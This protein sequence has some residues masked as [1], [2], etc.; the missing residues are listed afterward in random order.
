MPCAFADNKQREQSFARGPMSQIDSDMS[1][2][3]SLTQH[4][5]NNYASA[6]LKQRPWQHVEQIVLHLPSESLDETAMG[7]AWSELADAHP[8]L[9][10]VIVTE[11]SGTLK[12]RATPPM[13]IELVVHDW[14][15]F[16]DAQA[17]DALQEFLNEDREAGVDA[18]AAPAFRVTLIKKGTEQ[19][20]L[21]WTFSCTLLD[22]RACA[23]LL[24]EVFQR[25]ASIRNGDASRNIVAPKDNIFEA[26]CSKLAGMS[27]GDGEDHFTSALS[28]WDG[29]QGLA[30]PGTHPTRHAKIEAQ[31]SAAQTK[32]IAELAKDAGVKVST[33]VLAV[34][35]VVLARFSGQ[36]DV[37]F[38]NIRNGR[39]VVEGA[40][41]AAGCFRTTVPVRLQLDPSLTIG[42]L[43][44]N[45]RAEQI[46]ARPF[47]HTPLNNISRRLGIL[48]GRPIFDSTL[49]FDV[50]TLDEQLKAIRGAWT[51][52]HADLLEESD[53]PVTIVAYFGERLRIV[54]EYD[55]AQVPEGPGLA[56]SLHQFLISLE[57]A[58]PDTMLGAVSMLD[59]PALDRIITL[60][61]PATI[62]V[63]NAPTCI[64]K[65]EERAADQPN[66]IALM[67]P[68]C[69][70]ISYRALNEAAMKLAANL[71][72]AGVQSGDTL[73]ICMARGADFIV[74]MLAIWKAGA[75]FV[76]MDPSYPLKT[77]NV[78]AQDS[79]A[80]MVLI[81][82]TAPA[83]DALTCDIGALNHDVVLT[84][85][86]PSRSEADLA[87]VIFTSGSTGR[88]KGVMVTH[89]SLA[90]HAN[91]IVP[92]F[93]LTPKDRVLQFAA[94]SFDVALEEVIP[95]LVSGATLVLRSDVMSLS[96]T[97]FVDQT[98]ALGI[99]VANLPTG[100]WVALTE[101]LDTHGITFPPRIRLMVVGGERVPLSVLRR[102][103]A[104]QP[105]IRWLNGYGPTE[106]TITCTTYEA[107][108]HDLNGDTVP[109]GRPL[110]HV[111]AW[112]LAKDGALVPEGSEGELFISGPAV[113]KGYVGDPARTAQCFAPTVFD[114]GVGLSY[115]TGDRVVW[116][117]GLLHY[118][119][120]MDRQIKLRGFRIELGQIEAALES[121]DDIDRAHADVVVASFGEPQLVAWYSAP[122][123]T[124][125]PTVQQVK[126]LLNGVLPAQIQ[127]LPVAVTKWP[128]TPSGKV[129]VK[130]LPHPVI[131][132]EE[133]QETAA[134]EGSLVLKV[135]QLFAVILQ[136]EYVSPATSFFDAGGD[137]LSL[138]QL[139]PELEHK[140]GVKL[141][142]T[143]LYSD[144]SPQGVAHALQKQDPDPLVV[145]PIQTK[146]TLAPLYAVHVLG[147]NGSFF[148]PLA[149]V[150]GKEQPMY[151]LTVG[152]L[153][154][155]TP[156]S[157]RDIAEFYLQQI[158]RHHPEGPLSLIA[159]SLGSYVTLELA[160]QLQAAGRDVQAL[161]F[162]DADGPAGRPR[163]G[164]M[165]WGAVHLGA[166][167]RRG[168]PY[169][170]GQL[171]KRR[172]LRAQDAAQ[173]RLQAIDP[174]DA[175]I[176][177]KNIGSVED[178]VAANIIAADAYEPQPYNKKLT[179]FRA[180]DDKFDSNHAIKT[181]L[182]W[183]D[184]ATAGFN[185]T[186]VPG[187]HLGI[188]D[189]PNVEILGG[190]I[191]SLLKLIRDTKA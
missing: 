78:I 99:T 28:G 177:A 189:P 185:L 171:A 34:W 121:F 6:A 26:H 100:F 19:T 190:R 44:A 77:L 86:P 49:M 136:L 13:P 88:P 73:G 30:Q 84:F 102:W 155:N 153:S 10:N 72:A 128:Q 3:Y 142:P 8:A 55:P 96:L 147:D 173:Q 52:R 167:L 50:G 159:V 182:G 16:D 163:I 87:Y 15:R 69:A 9:N 181:G 114:A 170:A 70:D 12:Q 46:A 60:A 124:D 105:D 98:A 117:D 42:A 188:L 24:D 113:A 43:L 63:Q 120:R 118:L 23:P 154:A 145:I 53:T 11:E 156:T 160:Q 169:I 176:H 179:I 184:V 89:C 151:G 56:A 92:L 140:F 5:Q 61:G 58:T 186:D 57:A 104:R 139:I 71:A 130:C 146:G 82:A 90:A 25:Y 110:S 150:L 39:H 20:I 67:Q 187:D 149:S 21:V 93:E 132:A 161:I 126:E 47:E 143:A 14:Q 162:L 79:G 36:S 106:T 148:R 40:G 137:S 138:L 94:L 131:V 29:T 74:A 85:K 133:Q 174:T 32:A 45:I 27:H 101:V 127:P 83:L 103:R 166:I 135:A 91:S 119:G 144:P 1:A 123:G 129:D 134:L 122:S 107:T 54:V 157:V 66:H 64:D 158:E 65:F 109:I 180:A 48:P 7:Q 76:P 172:E 115:A 116:R 175:R 165:A 75:A 178:F 168:W 4:Q 2:P 38:G 164:H 112:V 97:E 152:L 59:A 108:T 125:L 191:R 80:Q 51:N 33:V 95:T 62:N 41:N 111:R 35:G 141:E 18:A 183:A 22:G 81:D 17:D 31:L 68:D 37:V